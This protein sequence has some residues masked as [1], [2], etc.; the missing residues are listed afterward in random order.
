MARTTR[1]ATSAARMNHPGVIT[2][3][4]VVEYDGAPWIVMEYIRGGSLA[5]EIARNGR[6]PW[7]RV[8]RIG[9]KIADALAHAHAAGVV[10][11]DLKPDNI[12][13]S[14]GPGGG[15]RLR[16]R[17]GDR[18]HQPADQDRDRDGNAALHGT[19]ELEG[20][21]VDAPADVWSLGATLYTTLEGKPPFD[22]PTLTAVIAAILA[23]D[24]VPPAQAGPL[25][26]LLMQM[27]VK[28]PAQRPTATAV[29][30]A[31][32]AC[33]PGLAAVQPARRPAATPP[34][35]TPPADT[36]P[37]RSPDPATVTILGQGAGAARPGRGPRRRS[38]PS[39]PA[40]PRPTRPPLTPGRHRPATPRPATPRPSRGIPRPSPATP[41]RVTRCG[42]ATRE[43]SPTATA[44]RR[45]QASPARPP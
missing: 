6:L 40:R 35:D 13:L 31:L 43:P 41:S 24:P 9:A 32:A 23:R 16:H 26:T 36:P 19:R 38:S 29:S 10:H 44:A 4:D 42:P 2:I 18:R 20:S 27:L 3:H 14:G 39:Y 34:A 5:A 17:P 33:P 11:R 45:R 30:E 22:G 37:S 21:D 8:A 7:Q 1:E 28:D 12:L 25:A 15:H